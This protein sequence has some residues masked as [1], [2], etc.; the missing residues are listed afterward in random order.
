MGL[1]FLNICSEPNNVLTGEL[2][3]TIWISVHDQVVMHLKP[4]KSL[5][6]KGGGRM[7]GPFKNTGL[8]KFL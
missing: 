2:F 3:H 5:K 1:F 4:T 8:A 7:N 6:N